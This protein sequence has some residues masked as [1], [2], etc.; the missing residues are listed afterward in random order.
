MHWSR[1]TLDASGSNYALNVGSHWT[2]NGTFNGQGGTVTFTGSGNIMGSVDTTFN[3]LAITSGT[4]T[5]N[6][7][8]NTNG[9]INIG[10]GT[11]LDAAG[12]NIY[13]KGNWTKNATASFTNADT[14]IFNG[15]S[16]QEINGTTPFGGLTLN[17]STG[18][19]INANENI[20]GTLTFTNGIIT[21]G[22]NKVII[23]GTGS[24]T[25]AGDGKYVYG[26]LQMHVGTGAVSRTFEVGTDIGYERVD[27]QFGNV[28]TGGNLLVTVTAS[29]HPN[30][31]TSN[32]DG[33]KA[34]NL[35]WTFTNDGIVLNPGSNYNATFHFTNNYKDGGADYDN[36]IVGKWDGVAGHIPPSAQQTPTIP[37]QP[38]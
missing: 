26:N 34:V 28:T 16:P 22:A 23:G 17:N 24:V 27:L 21:T 29:E 31:G 18:L 3:N 25:G 35:Y 32:I 4:R 7:D 13:V 38:D 12:H 2:N 5:L 1:H 14:V 37:R 36:F 11:T 20:N 30:L 9:Y 33:T 10:A 15:S 19:T 6:R 8:I